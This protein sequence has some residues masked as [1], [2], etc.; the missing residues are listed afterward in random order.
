MKFVKELFV[1]RGEEVLLEFLSDSSDPAD[2]GDHADHRDPAV[3]FAS[4]VN[5]VFSSTVSDSV[6]LGTF[7]SRFCV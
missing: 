2:F 6:F 7:V 1:K 4:G 5:D 3:P